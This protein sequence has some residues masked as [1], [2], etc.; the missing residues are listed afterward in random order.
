MSLKE[1]V[2]FNTIAEING[3]LMMY[4][5]LCVSALC[6]HINFEPWNQIYKPLCK[7]F[8]TDYFFLKCLQAVLTT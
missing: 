3:T 8:I 7:T 2:L 4:S 6:Q 5:R 1:I